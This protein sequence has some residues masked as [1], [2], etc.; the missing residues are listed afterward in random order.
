MERKVYL[1]ATC[2]CAAAL[3]QTVISAIRLLQR[4]GVRVVFRKD[5]TCCGQPAFN[6]GYFEE[7]RAVAMHNVE[8][9]EE[10]PELPVV[11]P[12]GSCAGMFGHELGELF[13]GDPRLERVQ[14]FA[15]R[16]MD[17]SQ[18]LNDVLQVEYEDR[19]APLRVTWHTSCHALRTQRCVSSQKALLARLKNVEVVPLEYEEECCGF[20]GTFSIREPEISNAMVSAKI[21]DIRHAGV[22]H[23]IAADGACILNIQGA[24]RHQHLDVQVTHLYDFLLDRLEG[25]HA[26]S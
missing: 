15:G 26:I 4:E 10:H 24:L 25:G 2:V 14:R 17:L 1:F 11:V 22:R 8:L 12:S 5:Q 3:P 23:V 19:G 7:A 21:S 6:A 20:G 9:F 13:R 18:Y 16:V